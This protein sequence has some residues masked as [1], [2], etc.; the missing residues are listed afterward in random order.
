MQAKISSQY[1]PCRSAGG[2]GKVWG[3]SSER[4]SG[5]LFALGRFLLLT[6]ALGLW[7]SAPAAT[8][9]WDGGGSNSKWSKDGNWNPDLAPTSGTLTDYVFAGTANLSNTADGNTYEVNS[10]TFSSGAG[11][12]TISSGNPFNLYSAGITNNSTADQTISGAIALQATS[13]I[14]AA[15]GN[16]ILSGAISGS[17]FGLTKTGSQTLTLLGTNTY[18]G[19]TA[20][21]GG[22]LALGASNV[23]AGTSSINVNGGTLNIATFS[24][25]VG[26]VTLTSGNINGTTGILTG[27][28]YSMQSGSVSA[29]LAGTG[30]NLTKSTAGTVTLSGTNTYTGVTTITGGSLSVSTIGN[31]GVAGN[32][33]QATSAAGNI[34]LNGGM[35][36]YTGAA[37][38][39]DRLFSV[40]TSGGSIDASGSGAL[41]L[42]NTGSIGFNGQTGARALTLTGTGSG[43]L[44]SVIG[45]NS[46]AT[47]LVKSGSGTWTLSGNNTFS[48]GTTLNAGTLKLSSATA[49]GTGAFTIAGGT[50]DN[51]SGGA[52]TLNNN[53]TQVWNGDFAFAGT[54]NVNTGTGN[55]TLSNSRAV[56]V[57]AGTLTVGGAIGDGGSTY[58]I[59]KAGNGTLA[60]AGS[61]ANTYTGMSTV[62]AG[63]LQLAKTAGVDAI[64][65]NL[66]IGAG[67]TVQLTAANQIKDTTAV[68]MSATGTPVF[69]LNGFSERIGSLASSNTSAAV[70]LGNPGSATTF[71]VGDSTNTT[72]SG[73]VSG[74]SN[75]AFTKEGTGTLTL[76]GT[77]TFTGAVSVNT[78][79]LN[80]QSNAG[81]GAGT[82]G[83]TVANG[84]SLALQGGITLNNGTLSLSGAGSSSLGALTNVSGNN[85]WTGNL[86]LANSATIGTQ[87]GTLT[88]GSTRPFFPISGHNQPSENGYITIGSQTLTFAGTGTA[89]VVNDR[90]RDFAGQVA[91]TSYT[92]PPLTLAY[93]PQTTSPGNVVV[94]MSNGGSVT[95]AANANS[96]TGS[97]TVQ[98]G[99]LYLAT[100]SNT[101]A[102]HDTVT[103]SFHSINGPLIIGSGSNTTTATVRL[104]ANETMAI[105][106]AVTLYKDGTL[107]VNDA[108]QTIDALTFNGG[109]IQ[110]GIGNLYLN[111]DVTVNASA[112]NTATISGPS[113]HLSL[114]LNRSGADTGP[115][116]TRT[117]NVVGGVGNTYDLSISANI[118]SGSLVKSGS[119][120]MMLNN[121]N[122]YT[123]TTSVTGG[124][125]NI[126][127]G[128]SSGNSALGAGNGT[129]N[130]GTSVS[131]GGTLQL[132]GG[133][134]VTTEMLT[135][136]GNG[137]NPGTGVLGALNNA[138]GSNTFGAANNTLINLAND[139]R[140]NASGG[141]LTIASNISSS[142]N[143]ALTV[144]GSGNTTITGAINTGVGTT[145][146]LSKDGTGM[147]TL[148]G[149]NSYQ[150][151]TA[152]TQGVVRVEH[153]FGLGAATTGSNGTF[154]TS[155][156][157][158]QLNHATGI[159]IGGEALSIAGAGIGG[160]SGALN[161]YGGNNSYGGLVTLTNAATIKSTAN[162]LTLAGGLASA[163]YGLTIVGGGDV[164]VSGAIANGSGTL[165]KQNGGTF[166]FAGTST[167]TTSGTVGAVDLQ[168]GRIKVGDGT[169]PTTLNTGNFDSVAGTTL[170]IASGGTVVATYTG[171]PT[172]FSGTMAGDGNFEKTGAGT[173]VFDSTWTASSLTLTLNGGTLSLLGAHI[174]VGTIHITGNTILDF[175]NSAGTFLS[176]AALV[177]DPGVTITVNNWASVTTQWYA[178][179]S[180][181]AG[182]LGGTD[183]VGGAP[184]G[185][186][187][188]GTSGVVFTGYTPGLTPTWVS[189]NHNGWFDHEIRPTPEPATYGAIFLAA[190]FGLV[191][192]RRW[193]QRKIALS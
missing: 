121:V 92:N 165:T 98:A 109:A 188:A 1:P 13:T 166:T 120:T 24:D 131:S 63:T 183:Q 139:A 119:G 67:G 40:G 21:S 62:N 123:G 42:T 182:T 48:G 133:V 126:Q 82:A 172:Y 187:T 148:S 12:F 106:T 185:T 94:N 95:F 32:L 178:T 65:G 122:D 81:L 54:N 7:A 138:S 171:A 159:T 132:Q 84:S 136:S 87:A 177:I 4:L 181:N 186:G 25:T 76:N 111:N 14:N 55:V 144:G 17:G 154:V 114:T 28:S 33:G 179:S 37:Q 73:V 116:A 103:D 50:F 35:L 85:S 110:L 53:N 150:G 170:E 151:A 176:S 101:A 27:S 162:T 91:S 153:M 140:I 64:A 69:N 11:A 70:Q 8:F 124:I 43:S 184:L 189:G 169:H 108:S 39:T 58:G 45:D 59:T 127:S 173:L 107:N 19:T 161:N 96:Y 193:R 2:R 56:T 191:G 60:F 113:G 34:I 112:G 128:T 88:L 90:I 75:A 147:L 141:T 22:T 160:I 146:T 137:Y 5:S 142:A 102:P 192:W 155:G 93:A 61:T 156:A 180:L 99:N 158:L 23:L 149:S 57:N 78:G 163:N 3:R 115:D 9:I 105:G 68:T 130:Q 16:V 38:S 86:T 74:G 6:L 72:F 117:F 46:G 134:A 164:T 36:A 31:G 83:T 125:L 18:T 15:S 135:L 30:A 29:I 152:I 44:A 89:I 118:Q 71:T 41:S 104:D 145:S 190:S 100:K 47:S 77:N 51:S 168:G 97:T 79:T 10:I 129:T 52:F 80:V 20:V 26:A 174:T 49:I 157:E 175:N 143:N 66:T 167:G